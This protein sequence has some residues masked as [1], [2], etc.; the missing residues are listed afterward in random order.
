MIPTLESAA[1]SLRTANMLVPLVLGDLTDELARRRTRDG[2]GPS[3]AWQVG[4]ILDFRCQLITM[5]GTPQKSPFRVPFATSGATDGA[6]Y[7][8]VAEFLQHWKRIEADLD[9]AL[10]D[11][12]EATIRRAVE[13]GGFHVGRP[14]LDAVAFCVFHE[15]YHVGALGAIRKTLGLPG[16]AELVMA[17]AAGSQRPA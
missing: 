9:A 8:T 1:A 17:Q 2:E 15:A 11:A 4:H 3:I 10:E 14:V 7:P 6:D 5:L 13:T 16:P 12:G